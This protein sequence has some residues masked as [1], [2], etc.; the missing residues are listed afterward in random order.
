MKKLQKALLG[1]AIAGTLVIGAGIGTYS[2]FT[3]EKTASGTI[4]NGTFGLAD[5]GTLFNQQKFAP[6]EV[7]FSDW[8]NVQNTG[9]L[10]QILRATY[11]HSVNTE[12]ASVKKYKVG[13]IALKFK[14]KPD[15][16]VFKGQ[17]IRLNALINGVTNDAPKSKAVS[18]NFETEEGILS[19]DQVNG[20]VKAQAQGQ[21]DN[22]TRTLT[23]GDGTKFWRL[24]E[25]E[26]IAILFG[27]KLSENAG[28]EFQGVGYTGEFKV[29]AKQT[30]DG[31]QY[32]SDLDAAKQ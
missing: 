29:E 5:M 13:Y 4:E 10:N 26:Y 27:V 18:S 7:V 9:N 31:A 2:W 6:S 30:D 24:K 1:T 15:K 3:A 12:A 21:G 32:Q 20:L 16:D 14:Q 11:T 8:Q 22:M 28:N 19:D 23:F 17:Q 25:G